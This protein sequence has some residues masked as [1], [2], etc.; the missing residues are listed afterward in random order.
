MIV[1]KQGGMTEFIPSP[2][3]KREGL[4]RD[5]IFELLLNIHSRVKDLEKNM[6]KLPSTKATQ[7]DRMYMRLKDEEKIYQE[8]HLQM[9]NIAS[10]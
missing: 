8:M 6:V 9:R 4:I 10:R 2:Q 3:E 1:K 5:N 7:F